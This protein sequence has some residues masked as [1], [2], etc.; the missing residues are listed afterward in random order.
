L[1]WES[2]S[3]ALIVT[4]FPISSLLP[5]IYR[6]LEAG[7]DLI[8]EAAPG[9]G[10]TTVVP[11]ALLSAA[12]LD[13]QKIIMLEPR[14]VAARA[15]AERMAK[16]LGERVGERVGYSVRF[17]RRVGPKTRLEVVTEGILTRRLQSDP[18]L[19]GVALVIFDEFHE[20]NLNSDL[21]L[22]LC[23]QARQLFRPELKLMLMSA[24]LNSDALSELLPSAPVLSSEGRSFPVS[25]H[26][27]SR[28]IANLFGHKL[29]EALSSQVIQV[30]NEHAG[31][32]LVFLPGRAEIIALQRMLRQR[33]GSDFAILPMHGG[34]NLDEQRA[35]IASPAQG[36][37]KIVLSTDIA[38]TSLTI[39]GV[40]V[41]VDSGLCR[42]PNFDAKTGISRL[43]TQRVSRAS[44]VQRAGRAGR[45][46][47]GHCYRLWTRDEHST[48]APQRSPEILNQD[49]SGLLLQCISWGVDK[50][51]EL[52]WVDSPRPA[53]LTH[54]HQVLH[55]LG[56]L[57]NGRLT[58]LGERA[59]HL[60][61]EPRLS[62]LLL[63]GAQA[64]ALEICAKLAALLGEARRESV[65]SLLD[66]IEHLDSKTTDISWSRRVRKSAQQYSDLIRKIKLCE[67]PGS[68]K[69]A[70]VNILARAFPDFIARKRGG[71]DGQYLLANG[72]A[73]SLRSG[74]ELASYEYLV[75]CE[76][77]GRE[78]QAADQIF[79][80]MPL[81]SNVL[82]EELDDLHEHKTVCE[83]IEGKFISEQ[84]T[85]VGA[86]ILR[87]EP[88]G[89]LTQE[90][91][92][93]AWLDYIRR[94]GLEVLPWTEELCMWRARVM[95]A[96]QYLGEP[97]PDLSDV[98]LV[99]DIENWLSA[100]LPEQ[101]NLNSLKQVDL[102]GALSTLLKW[103]LPSELDR[104]LPKRWQV[105]SGSKIAINYAISPPALEVKLQ[106]MFGCDNTPALLDGRLAM[107]IH[108]LSPARR[109]L[110]ITQDLKGFWR[111][112]YHEIKKEMKGRYPK[113]PWPDEPWNA[114]ASRLTKNALSAKNKNK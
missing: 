24:T 23:L 75:V 57:E 20:R 30:I 69:D 10:K 4:E 53:A 45:L 25:E 11:L 43:A 47:A 46:S 67:N 28:S 26:F 79:L 13:D 58:E 71:V 50:L 18:E 101:M 22:A 63:R 90:Q 35:A 81:D 91:I 73:A 5:D 105:A 85:R 62:C 17:D 94:C 109:P 95:L 36:L 84:Q 97:W 99:A 42:V 114:E 107:Q 108:I 76:L 66:L 16:M 64:G 87:R 1:L 38:E 40:T 112:S 110:Q 21:G 7:S 68:T 39:E 44:A 111:G 54:A 113:H 78:G 82:I 56:L 31:H 102:A 15:A 104:L 9:A 6:Y 77:G 27:L 83:W 29:C 93:N 103:P 65:D 32:V 60:P 12:W 61:L 8:L 3:K 70:W 2:Y 49:L 41:V 100:F 33:L 86:L 52:D 55:R 19:N 48:L 74:S 96:H 106:E 59:A 37:R 88:I 14:R 98:H 89:K 72:R 34:L 92:K 51:E 80:A